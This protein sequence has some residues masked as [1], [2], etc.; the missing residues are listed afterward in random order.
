[1]EPERPIEKL[2]RTWA[3]KRRQDAEPPLELHPATRRLLQGEVARTL[4]KQGPQKR[5]FSTWLATVWPRFVWG[6]GVFGVLAVAVWIIVPPS[7]NF[8]GER[9]LAKHE[10]LSLKDA[11]ENASPA[12]ASSASSADSFNTMGTRAE[13]GVVVREKETAERQLSQPPSGTVG[14]LSRSAEKRGRDNDGSVNT[15][16]G[17]KNMNAPTLR[18]ELADKTKGEREES[19]ATLGIGAG[20]PATSAPAWAAANGDSRGIA[21][22]TAASGQITNPSVLASSF[23]STTPGQPS[24]GFAVAGF[25]G[26]GSTQQPMVAA[27]PAAEPASR[28]RPGGP[29]SPRFG[30]SG[31]ATLSGARA[32]SASRTQPAGATVLGADLAVATDGLQITQK[33][34]TS[35]IASA[36]LALAAPTA[37]APNR[38]Y[39]Y[40]DKVANEP[41]NTVQRF[42]RLDAMT[43]AKATATGK[44]SAAKAVLTSF[45]I[46]RVGSEVRIV[47]GDGSLYTGYVQTATEATRSRKTKAQDSA[48]M[49]E[50]VR[51][52]GATVE[53]GALLLRDGEAQPSPNYFFRVVGTNR[54]LNE[55]ITFSGQFTAVTDFTKPVT[56]TNSALPSSAAGRATFQETRTAASAPP[57]VS[58]RVV[59][60]LTVGKGKEVDVNAVP[61]GK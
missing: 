56:T 20:A 16:E 7:R 51:R 50:N 36:T 41:T 32:G 59:G 26:S 13:S 21:T 12:P 53:H 54:T 22:I 42:A 55:N 24:P 23:T 47:D 10:S 4:G 45:E 34:G 19:K 5:S 14:Q 18:F 38:S 9:R 37:S 11:L 48:A 30:A 33:A 27:A 61:T 49:S 58:S 31:P 3:K 40:A 57:A 2:L 35:G 29:A 46:T 43:K 15:V 25:S 44:A 1:M 17:N 52:A 60:K 8:N 6:L 28:V 39:F